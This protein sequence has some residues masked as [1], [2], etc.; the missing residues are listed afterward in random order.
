MPDFSDALD[1]VIE[2]PAEYY[3]HFVSS[4]G[5]EL[6]VLRDEGIPKV[7]DGV[8]GWEVVDR[9]RRRGLTKWNGRN[10]IRMD[11]PI[12]FD[13]DYTPPRSIDTDVTTLVNMAR[14]DNFII[15]PTVRVEGYLPVTG[16]KWVIEDL[17]W[18]DNARWKS[19]GMGGQIRVRQD[20]VVKLLQYIEE[21]VV[22]TSK[23]SPLPQ[24]SSYTTKEG[25]TLRGISKRFYGTGDKWKVIYEANKATVPFL[26]RA[27]DS[28]LRPYVVLII[29]K[30]K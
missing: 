28:P 18:G 26:S 9:R 7:T 30:S 27:P 17:N 25:D 19:D 23:K 24:Q 22:R 29:P 5:L 14:G 11:V 8:G 10:P 2:H 16:I 3:Y 21:D 12:L 15:P 13:G 1:I 20:C 6:V 4:N